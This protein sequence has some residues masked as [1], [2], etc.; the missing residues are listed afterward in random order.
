MLIAPS[1][2]THSADQSVL[3]QA[4]SEENTQL[5]RQLVWFKNQLFGAKSEKR[6]IDN[7]DQLLLTGLAGEA[8]PPLPAPA[9]QKIIFERG[10]GKKKRDEGCV[11]IAVCV[12]VPMCRLRRLRS[13]R[14]SLTALT[15]TN[16][17]S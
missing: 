2:D 4:L 16:T 6:V 14:R 1:T 17:T 13:T 12:L 8:A 10:K 5:K 7:P 3:L 15:L 11:T 9:K